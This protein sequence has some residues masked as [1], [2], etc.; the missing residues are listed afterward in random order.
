MI[1][2]RLS[3]KKYSGDL[4]GK[5][6]QKYGGRWNSPGY[7]ILY[8]S[9]SIAL[10]TVEVAVHLPFGYIPEEYYLTSIE[11]PDSIKITAFKPTDLPKNWNSMAPIPATKK[12]GDNFIK[13]NKHLVLQVPSASVQGDFNYLINPKHKDFSKVKIKKT[14]PFSF[15]QRLFV[16]I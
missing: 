2:Y 7:R 10:C 11:I 3:R 12:I 8:T 1:V 9:Q 5:G 14:E 15:D 13:E 4:T 6:S 16:R